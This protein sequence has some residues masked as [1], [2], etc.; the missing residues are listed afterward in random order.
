MRQNL[1]YYKSNY[2][3]IVGVSAVASIVTNPSL[4]VSLILLAVGWTFLLFK[5]PR[6]MDG[7]LVPVTV[8]GRTLSDF[9]QKA[10]MS[11]VTIL[12]M[13]ITGLTGT[14]FASLG[15]SVF[16]VGGH[17]ALHRTDMH[18]VDATDFGGEF[19]VVEQQA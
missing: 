7:A 4:L 14:I 6:A 9:E 17:A 12:L 13:L 15:L 3:C 2:A 19:A 5:R 18:E 11:G 1:A 10:G 16:V 8:G